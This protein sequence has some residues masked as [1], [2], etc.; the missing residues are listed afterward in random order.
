ME[1]LHSHAKSAFSPLA[2]PRESPPATLSHTREPC[3]KLMGKDTLIPCIFLEHM[4]SARGH[5]GGWR[6]MGVHQA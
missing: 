2:T 6:P 1:S 4:L 3:D 5:D